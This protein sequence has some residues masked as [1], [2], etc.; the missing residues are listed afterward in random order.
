METRDTLLQ[1]LVGINE[2]D[3]IRV[4][5]TQMTKLVS[6]LGA[7]RVKVEIDPNAAKQMASQVNEIVKSIDLRK[8]YIKSD[9]LFPTIE[10]EHNEAIRD[11]METYR[12]FGFALDRITRDAEGNLIS[13]TGKAKDANGALKTLRFNAE[14]GVTGE[15][16]I[17]NTEKQITSMLEKAK[18]AE[19]ALATLQTRIVQSGGKPSQL[20]REA[21][22]LQQID[23]LYAAAAVEVQNSDRVTEDYRQTL[24]NNIAI[25][26]QA[27]ETVLNIA[28][29]RAQ[30]DRV[31][32]DSFK[33][34][35]NAL[36]E[37]AAVL[38]R[39]NDIQLGKNTGYFEEDLTKNKLEL[40][41]LIGT[42][43]EYK[44]KLFEAREAAKE[45]FKVEE[46]KQ[47]KTEYDKLGGQ[48]DA[49]GIKL[50]KAQ[51][52]L[53][54]AKLK[55]NQQDAIMYQLSIE[56]I[57]QEMD[58]L[59]IKA[60]ELSEK[61]RIEDGGQ[62]EK[63][64]NDFKELRQE[65]EQTANISGALND[66]FGKVVTTF[67]D[68]TAIGDAVR[69]TDDLSVG[70]EALGKRLLG[71][72]ATVRKLDK[73][74]T[75]FN[76]MTKKVTYSV[77]EADGQFKLYTY[78]LD[79]SSN[80]LRLTGIQ[81]DTAAKKIQGFKNQV[82][83]AAKKIGLWGVSTKLVYG[84]FQSFQKG[85]ETVKEL[86]KE[87]TQI[88]VVQG[89]TRESVLHLGNEYANTAI[90]MA[91]TVQDVAKL[92]TEL[93]RQGLNLEESAE[94]ASVI[95]KLSSAGMLSMEQ[96]LQVITTGVNALGVAQEKVADVILKASMLSASDV[97]GLGEAFSK[98]ASGAKAAGLSIEETT[99]L[100]ATMKDITQEGDSQL[101]TSLKSMLARFNKINEETGDMNEDLNEVQTA[102]ESVG[103]AFTESDGQIRS[104][105]DIVEDLSGV[106]GD[107]D[108][109]TKSYIA[110]QAAGVRQQNRFFAVMD[111]FNKV[112]AINNDLAF[113][114]GT[115]QSSYATYMT[116][117]EAAAQRLKS[118]L[119][120]LWMGAIESDT[121][122]ALYET[123][124]VILKIIDHVGLLE[125]ALSSALSMYFIKKISKME[126][127]FNGLGE[128]I[129]SATRAI[130]EFGY[131]QPA[132]KG[133]GDAAAAAG[134]GAAVAGTGFKG[135]A[136]SIG[137]TKTA[138]LGF[139]GA[140][141]GAV[142]VS[143]AIGKA[144]SWFTEQQA[145][146][147]K[148]TARLM[149]ITKDIK[150]TLGSQ[151]L[152]L[153][154]M[155]ENFTK[156]QDY[157]S[158]LSELNSTELKEYYDLNNS[159]IDQYPQLATQVDSMGRTIVAYT[160]K[161]EDLNAAYSQLKSEQ[162]D[163]FRENIDKITKETKK[164]V[165]EAEGLD[166]IQKE[167]DDLTYKNGGSTMASF[168]ETERVG[169]V[170]KGKEDEYNQ[171]IEE[172]KDKFIRAGRELMSLMAVEIQA[173]SGEVSNLLMNALASPQ[174]L[175][176]VGVMWSQGLSFDEI[177]NSQPINEIRNSLNGLALDVQ[178]LH[179]PVRNL[180]SY[181]NKLHEEYQYGKI[182]LEEY[183]NKVNAVSESTTKLEG[184]DQ[185]YAESLREM[186]ALRQDDIS[187][188]EKEIATEDELAEARKRTLDESASAYE[189]SGKAA[190]DYYKDLEL[191]NDS[192]TTSTQIEDMILSKYPQWAYMMNDKA[193]LS[194]AFQQA[195]MAEDE[196]RTE[197]YINMLLNTESFVNATGGAYK[198]LMD[199]IREYYKGD[200]TN[201]TQLENAKAQITENFINQLNQQ[202]G[203]YFHQ[204]NG[205]IEVNRKLVIDSMRMGA[206]GFGS[207]AEAQKFIDGQVS[208]LNKIANEQQVV[209]NGITSKVDA[210]KASI[211]VPDFKTFA[212]DLSDIGK[213]GKS[214]GKGID[215][216]KKAI[217]EY[218]KTMKATQDATK[219]VFDFALEYINWIEEQKREEIEKTK[220]A[221]IE[222]AESA[223]DTEIELIDKALE[224]Q[225]EILDAKEAA[226]K[227]EEETYEYQKKRLE[228]QD[229]LVN[230]EYK[231]ALASLDTSVS[232]A[233]RRK[234]LMES[235][236][237][238]QENLDKLE[239][240]RKQTLQEE[241][242][243]RQRAFIQNQAEIERAQAEATK[244]A[245]IEK[246]EQEYTQKNLKL[247]QYYSAE[248][249][250]LAAVEATQ[251]G[252]I[253]NLN[254]KMIPLKQAFKEL[255]IENERFWTFFGQ[256]EVEEFGNT[257]TTVM[258][259]IKKLGFETI[260]TWK[261]VAT[262]ATNAS[263]AASSA[264]SS[265]SSA[266]G[267]SGY[268]GTPN[269]PPS[270][271]PPSQ[272]NQTALNKQY[273]QWLKNLFTSL[274][275]T[276]P[277][278]FSV[279]GVM[280]P[281][282]RAAS[283]VAQ[284]RKETN[285]A[286]DSVL[287][288]VAQGKKV[289]D[290]MMETLRKNV[291]ST[292]SGNTIKAYAEGGKI[293]YTGPAQVHGSKSKPEYVFNYQQ[294]KDLSKMI[295]RH[296]LTSV[297]K[298]TAI[299]KP[300]EIKFDNLI[301]VE[302]SIDKDSLPQVKQVAN[303]AID[304]LANQ[305]K[306]WGK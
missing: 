262:A 178:G 87:L 176:Q 203:E 291:T 274:K 260:Q 11:A 272:G 232:G 211:N 45:A 156:L 102:I 107:L 159:L 32:A 4:I 277:S 2:E 96:S 275:L 69:R 296:E 114:A 14:G 286:V 120:K 71:Q 212:K 61:L 166:E 147:A 128:K 108:K 54:K 230:L 99:S 118:T 273:Q 182:S 126:G 170:R 196:V 223:Y 180:D 269:P 46:L 50:Q 305:L 36:K 137:L 30:A 63:K 41:E 252:M 299:T 242:F 123:G 135:M 100:L 199:G 13:F 29:Q 67:K 265:A 73:D 282:T 280:G 175:Q 124:T 56:K 98:T 300:V 278:G 25:Q 60:V 168:Y 177:L 148:E 208:R 5:N 256:Q 216:A 31:E 241:W 75:N 245:K 33:E 92:N 28:R 197:S 202:W 220:D 91:Q 86:D 146:A 227:T 62:I 106:W 161:L 221:A 17:L 132:I 70:V 205:Y 133:A 16:L 134:S 297:K 105:Y 155:E 78:T 204:V 259:A 111:N 254:G 174:M 226:L 104:F 198:T 268:R 225:K 44:V 49:L 293:D 80:S 266:G 66:A 192:K 246:A 271:T 103:V 122:T 295:A 162:L 129:K 189:K 288:S 109:N 101:G 261:E 6:K 257:V 186:I 38:K 248:L 298:P 255:A 19:K 150:D 247:D 190:M 193:A 97:E 18:T 233:A 153:F 64:I 263:N 77:K 94:R 285:S 302:G 290:S 84:S 267:S 219:E 27:G 217:D 187:K 160:V 26:K 1:Y 238:E 42:T 235:L 74:N 141:A 144:V 188:L 194:Q 236:A 3:S 88:A 165:F 121:L 279:D 237:E 201:Y 89:K 65:L 12:E 83:D 244:I 258:E 250:Y 68:G 47:A 213:K 51:V 57:T 59:G 22:L 7:M 145:K 40:E 172:N 152:D 289:T 251:S 306:G 52:N 304:K 139:A 76:Q 39:L 37:Y 207:A 116:G 21:E 169:Q 10:G 143:W 281:A 157:R 125:L 90:K 222:A 140:M 138:V 163:K 72:S 215:A 154:E 117:T 231:L 284:N 287:K 115:L 8:N 224:Q 110:T 131:V 209:L 119:D 228:L 240:D 48:V 214:A 249:N 229:S 206:T 130:K 283:T 292:A 85:I 185:L 81:T 301:K 270:P 55:G 253:E 195:M 276:L 20:S 181:F 15:T 234:T 35:E 164:I 136:A 191:L 127:G 79:K 23:G 93:V 183:K 294:F 149:E 142:A 151:N 53:D 82:M 158:R 113:A 243:A 34:K 179:L 24:L 95:M 210:F 43:S 171:I 218:N 9:N 112:Q 173:Q 200:I 239:R 184:T 303:D 167:L 58:A 264:A